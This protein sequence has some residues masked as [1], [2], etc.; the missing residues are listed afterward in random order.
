MTYTFFIFLFLLLSLLQQ[1]KKKK[2]KK[3]MINSR[4]MNSV[5]CIDAKNMKVTAQSGCTVQQALKAIRPYGMTLESIPSIMTQQMGGLTQVSAQG[6]GLDICSCDTQVAPLIA[7]DLSL[8]CATDSVI[9]TRQRQLELIPFV[10]VGL[11]RLGVVMQMTLQCVKSHKLNEEVQVYSHKELAK[12]MADDSW[13]QAHQQTTA[14]QPQGFHGLVSSFIRD[15][16]Q[17]K[18]FYWKRKEHAYLT[19]AIVSS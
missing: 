16:D 17:C 4:K 9:R 10:R 15:L 8:Q 5:L 18:L 19:G 7:N 3:R 14:G 6:T 11:G 2:T 12:K 1:Q 13:L